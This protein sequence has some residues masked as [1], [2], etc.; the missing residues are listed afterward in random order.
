[1]K[2]CIQCHYPVNGENFNDNLHDSCMVAYAN[3]CA[4]RNRLVAMVKPLIDGVN[5]G[6]PADLADAIVE[7]LTHNHRTLQQSFL[8]AF[9]LALTK[10]AALNSGMYTDPRNQCAYEWA[11]EV[12]KLP[13]SDLRFPLI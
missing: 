1:M 9:K 2:N 10:Y 12:A 6:N 3:A 13:N 5:G 8:G 4:E 11:Q 7:A